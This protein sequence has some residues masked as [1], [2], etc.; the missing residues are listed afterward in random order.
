MVYVMGV[1]D[2]KIIYKLNTIQKILYVGKEEEETEG[3]RHF[4][5]IVSS[6]VSIVHT[7]SPMSYLRLHQLLIDFMD[8]WKI[9]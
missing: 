8:F 4:F 6:S 3:T 1:F 9:N 7:N 5:H 2:Y